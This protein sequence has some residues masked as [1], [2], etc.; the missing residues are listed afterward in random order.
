[1]G[2]SFSP[3]FPM[4]EWERDVNGICCKGEI[5]DTGKL[6]LNLLLWHLDPVLKPQPLLLLA[7]FLILTSP[8]LT[9]LVPALTSCAQTLPPVSAFNLAVIKCKVYHLYHDVGARMDLNDSLQ[10]ASE[11]PLELYLLSPRGDPGH[12]SPKSIKR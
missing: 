12:T 1:M 8:T 6:A 2:S 4:W 10:W 9:H 5:M 3:A 11:S 7:V